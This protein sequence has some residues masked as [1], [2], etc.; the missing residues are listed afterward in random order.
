M[1]SMLVC[2]SS[3]DAQTTWSLLDEG[4]RSGQSTLEVPCGDLGVFHFGDIV[5]PQGC[6]PNAQITETAQIYPPPPTNS[7]LEMSIFASALPT[8]PSPWTLVLDFKGDH[9]SSTTEMHSRMVPSGVD[10]VRKRLDTN[11]LAPLGS[12][13]SDFHVLARLCAVAES[14]DNR[15]GT[16][17]LA[18]NMSFGRAS[19]AGDP[20]SGQ[21]C[22]VDSI[23]CHLTRVIEHLT[24]GPG[25]SGAVVVAAAGNQRDLLFPAS[26]DMVVAASMVDTTRMIRDGLMRPAWESPASYDALFPGNSL[27]LDDATALASGSSYSTSLASGMIAHARHHDPAIDPASV[28][29]WRPLH[30]APHNC[31]RL[32]LDWSLVGPCHPEFGEI[33]EGLAGGYSDTCWASSF[34]SPGTEYAP[35]QNQPDLPGWAAWTKLV[36]PTP[37]ADP[38]LPCTGDEQDNGGGGPWSTDLF[39]DTSQSSRLPTGTLLD[40]AYLR[41]GNNFHRLMLS[42]QQ[43]ADLEQGN[44]AGITITGGG[45]LIQLSP[46]Q[47][48]MF[49]ALKT[50][51]AADCSVS[52]PDDPVCFFLSQPI[53]VP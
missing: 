39:V 20:V 38:C 25:S 44:L 5:V 15:A 24:D 18:I 52:D 36:G 16:Y 30:W 1:L 29:R 23:A 10:V 2:V 28:G 37:E 48:S 32:G 14:V 49:F 22:A 12:V 33:M 21:T 42:P 6:S 51:P 26:I 7:Y 46:T 4:C 27:C 13:V 11:D 47:P 19:I 31:Y 17:P 3:A 40:S 41:V 34:F 43:I 8:T 53:L 50:D 35:P 45:D 9:G